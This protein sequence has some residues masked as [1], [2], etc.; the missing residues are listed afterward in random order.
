MWHSIVFSLPFILA[1]A[2]IGADENVSLLAAAQPPAIEAVVN[3]ASFQPGFT[4]GS[5]LTIKGSNLATST[6]TWTDADIVGGKLPTHLDGTSVTVNGKAAYVYYV[7]PNQVNILAPADTAERLVPVQVTCNGISGNVVNARETALAPALFMFGPQSQKYVAA[8]RADGAYIGP[9]DLFGPTLNTVPAQHGDRVLLF[10]TG[11]GATNPPTPIGTVFGTASPT[12]IG[13]TATVGDIAATV[14]FAG[15]I[16]PGLYQFNLLIPNGAPLG[17]NLVQIRIGSSVTQGSAFI[18]VG[19]PQSSG[20]SS[21]APSSDLGSN[22]QME[23]VTVPAGEFDMGCSNGDTKCSADM[24]PLHHVRISQ[25]FDIGK[26]EVTQEQWTTVM[27]KLQAGVKTP[28]ARVS[29]NAIEE[30]VAKLNARK[31][32]YIYGLPTEAQWEYAARAGRNSFLTDSLDGIAWTAGNSGGK[33]NPVGLKQPNDWD[34]YDMIGNVWEWVSDEYDPQYYKYSPT[35]DPWGADPWNFFDKNDYV[36]RGG[37]FTTSSTI[38]AP[39]LAAARGPLYTGYSDD[40]LGF[41]CVRI[42]EPKRYEIAVK[43]VGSGE[44]IGSPSQIRLSPYPM[45]SRVTGT[46]TG[47]NCGVNCTQVSGSYADGA[48]VIL[49]AGPVSQFISWSGDCIGSSPICRLTVDRALNVTATFGG[50]NVVRSTLFTDL[51]NGVRMEFVPV[52]AGKFVMGCSV[53]DTLCSDREKAPHTVTI[54]KPFELGI[55]EVTQEQF[56]SVLTPGSDVHIMFRPTDPKLARDGIGYHPEAYNFLAKL[57]ARK[58]GYVYR[59]PT[60]AEWEYVARAGSSEPYY[61]DLDEIA[62]HGRNS[63][64]LQ[65]VGLKRPNAWGVYDMIGNAFEM[66]A[67]TT[68]ANMSGYSSAPAVDPIEYGSN[69]VLRGGSAWNFDPRVLRVTYRGFSYNGGWQTIGFRVVRQRQ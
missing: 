65:H 11:F 1:V 22:V 38:G 27:G 33:A 4:Q 67:D 47:I 64:Q 62:W 49:T 37:G 23:F 21:P 2:P 19:A 28:V 10:G 42:K 30:F 35:V 39:V 29:Y 46:P 36:L 9:I 57:N 63:G 17:D 45:D 55:Y 12:A 13:V 20:S 5:W 16:G 51:G 15:L 40:A 61:G 3:G 48:T 56:A 26:H 54:T 34:L 41:R 69:R 66:V 25:A 58:D 32:G 31:D 59:L 24:K 53:R 14:E 50:E 18:I 6:R 68:D 52:P 8:V 7:S 44:V 60:E 43:K